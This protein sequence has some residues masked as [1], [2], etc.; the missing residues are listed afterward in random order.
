MQYTGGG[1][2]LNFVQKNNI[3]IESNIK[4]GSLPFVHRRGIS[5]N[6]KQSP[7]FSGVGSV[8]ISNNNQSTVEQVQRSV[9]LPPSLPPSFPCSCMLTQSYNI[10]PELA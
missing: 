1:G 4:K 7:K 2:V 3:D 8:T 6:F 9:T 10:V 5:I